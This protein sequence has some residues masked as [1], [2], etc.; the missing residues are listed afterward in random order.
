MRIFAL[1]LIALLL[2]AQSI[3]A[4]WRNKKLCTSRPVKFTESRE[5]GC[6]HSWCA[7]DGAAGELCACLRDVESEALRITW[8]RAGISHQ[9]SLNVLPI[10]LDGGSFL[11]QA[12]DSKPAADLPWLFAVREAVSNGMGVNYWQAFVLGPQGVSKPLPVQDLSLM[13]Q[14][15]PSKSCRLLAG[16]WQEGYESRRGEGKYFVA[17]WQQP[18]AGQ[19]QAVSSLP[20]L[21]RRYLFAFENER[22]AGLGEQPKPVLWFRHPTTRTGVPSQAAMQK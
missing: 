19:W 1:A 5:E 11:L 7:R 20:V 13:T 14:D 21:H 2:P 9:W 4:D 10:Q 3:A 12:F 15:H 8:R 6:S 16:Q 17:T 18:S 22:L